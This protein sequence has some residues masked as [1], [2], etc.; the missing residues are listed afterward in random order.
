MTKA[1][2]LEKS[3]EKIQNKETRQLCSDVL[4]RWHIC[5]GGA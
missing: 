1:E 5:C 4:A 2:S 3:A